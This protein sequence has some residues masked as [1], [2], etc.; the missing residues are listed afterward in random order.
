MFNNKKI[1]VMKEMDYC[2]SCGMPLDSNKVLGT[3]EDGSLN[4]DYCVYCFE[5]GEFTFNCTMEEMI[6]SC[7]EYA[8]HWVPPLTREKAVAEMRQYFPMLKRWKK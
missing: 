3:N 7:A 4:R 2:Q 8:D 1:S 5:N 6:N